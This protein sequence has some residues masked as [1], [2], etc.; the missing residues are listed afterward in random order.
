[1]REGEEAILFHKATLEYESRLYPDLHVSKFG[2]RREP[3]FL[4]VHGYTRPV[5]TLA[6]NSV[7]ISLKESGIYEK[8][9][10]TSQ[11]ARSPF[12]ERK[13]NRYVD[14]METLRSFLFYGFIVAF[15]VF[16]L[17]LVFLFGPKLAFYCYQ[18]LL[19][20]FCKFKVSSRLIFSQIYSWCRMK[21]EWLRNQLKL[22]RRKQYLERRVT[23]GHRTVVFS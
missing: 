2:G 14:E 7:I 4:I 1:M 5:M 19:I 16:T 18:K 11:S 15:F 8:W 13:M 9:F 23:V 12:Q 22:V 17:E 6:I 3:Y 21:L 20:A 10:A